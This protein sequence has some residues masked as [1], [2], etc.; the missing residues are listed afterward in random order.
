MKVKNYIVEN[1]YEFMDELERE[2]CIGVYL[3]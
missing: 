3:M 1:C 2:L